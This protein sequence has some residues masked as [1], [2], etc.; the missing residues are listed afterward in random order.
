MNTKALLLG[1]IIAAFAI[2]TFATDAL[3]TPRAKG[4]QIKVI[5]SA[6][7]GTAIPMNYVAS[8]PTASPRVNA[9]QIKVVKGVLADQ[10]PALE[11]LQNMQGTPRAV[12]ACSQSVTMPGCQKLASK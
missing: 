4:N 1:T 9:A 3:L 2:S 7:E 8:T 10:N 12:T 5:A 6:P 11:C